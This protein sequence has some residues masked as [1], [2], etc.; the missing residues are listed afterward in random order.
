VNS[1]KFDRLPLHIYRSGA[2]KIFLPQWL[3]C[4]GNEVKLTAFWLPSGPLSAERAAAFSM[5]NVQE[6]SRFPD[7]GKEA[8]LKSG[9]QITDTLGSASTSL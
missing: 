2:P 3:K 6:G 8:L 7:L 5:V 1:G 4:E 9:A